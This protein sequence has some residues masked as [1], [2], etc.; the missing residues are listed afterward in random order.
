MVELKPFQIKGRDFLIGKK[1]ACLFCEMGTGKSA[2]AIKAFE[3]LYN[4][5]KIKNILIVCPASLRINWLREISKWSI[6]NYKDDIKIISYDYL[7]NPKNV[8]SLMRISWDCV[9]ADECHR[10]RNWSA[11]RTKVFVRELAPK[12]KYLWGLTGTP[13]K[14]SA[15]DLHPLFSVM[16]PGIWGKFGDFKEEYCLKKKDNWSRAGFKYYGVKNGSILKTGWQ[17]FALRRLKRDVAPQLPK[18]LYTDLIVNVDPKLVAQIAEFDEDIIVQAVRDN[19]KIDA[20]LATL[21]RAVGIAKI[22]ALVEWLEGVNDKVVVFTWHRD[23]LFGLQTAL[24]KDGVAVRHV[25]GGMS[26][27]K[28]QDSV[29]SFMKGDTKVLIVSIG[30]GSEGKNLNVSSYGVFLELCWSPTDLKQAEDRLS[31]IDSKQSCINYY[32]ILAQGCF[33]DTRLNALERK[34]KYIKSVIGD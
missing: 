2:Q 19:T 8:K 29:D 25:V 9:V 28:S 12:V 14:N 21:I 3:Y 4:K 13:Q 30:A 16:E 15:M 7:I 23:V 6:I 17:R 34:D 18:K 32:R 26:D 31:R 5:K 27:S 20:N 10:I 22:P 24:E 33:E 11:K 1:R